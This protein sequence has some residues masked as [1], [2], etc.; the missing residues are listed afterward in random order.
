VA[1]SKT[2][3]VEVC[4]SRERVQHRAG[5]DERTQKTGF[6]VVVQHHEVSPFRRKENSFGLR[7]LNEV[8]EPTG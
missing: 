4:S 7:H 5:R 3:K 2:H 8:N 6:N 1:E